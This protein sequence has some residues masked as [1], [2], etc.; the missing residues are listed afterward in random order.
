MGGSGKT[1]L[2]RHL[3]H[4]AELTGLVTRSFYYGWDA[5]AWTRAQILRD[6][7]PHVLPPD[8]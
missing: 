3:A 7:A 5:R 8:T 1:T 6:L 2:L 4:W